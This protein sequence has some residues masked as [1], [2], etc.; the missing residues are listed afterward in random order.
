MAKKLNLKVFFTVALI[1]SAAIGALAQSARTEA[2]T[3]GDMAPD[4]TLSDNS[5]KRVTLSD[6]VKEAPVVLVF[7]RGYWC[8]FCARQLSDLRT[9]LGKSDKARMYAVSI[10]PSEKTNEMITKIEADGKGKITYSFLSDPGA[11][12]IDAYGLRDPRYKGQNVDGVPY[13]TV[14]VIGRDRKV[15]WSKL[16]KDYKIRPTNTEIRAEIEKLAMK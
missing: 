5:G 16:E 2:I 7:Y 1:L 6:A 8:P 3:V 11:K 10:D 15:A 13:P 14:Y 12:T 9:L 4:F